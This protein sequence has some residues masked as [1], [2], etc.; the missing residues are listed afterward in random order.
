MLRLDPDA[1]VVLY[2]NEMWGDTSATPP[3]EQ[4]YPGY[5]TAMIAYY[6]HQYDVLNANNPNVKQL[7]FFDAPAIDLTT[8]VDGNKGALNYLIDGIP[9]M[10]STPSTIWDPQQNDPAGDN[11]G[12]YVP[13]GIDIQ[14]QQSENVVTGTVSQSP[15]SYPDIVDNAVKQIKLNDKGATLFAGLTTNNTGGSGDRE[16]SASEIQAAV[17]S[18]PGEVNGYWLNDAS[19]SKNGCPSCTGPYPDL[20]DGAV[21]LIG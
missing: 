8:P 10:A 19:G 18:I 14:A 1:S 7:K 21:N 4:K 17:G 16:T 3:M 2:D 20:A 13:D 11:F 6:V 15:L 9:E 5:F 12:S